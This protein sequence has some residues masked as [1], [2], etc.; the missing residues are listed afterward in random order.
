MTEIT[1]NYDETWKEAIGDYFDSFLAFFYPEIYQQI[2]WSKTPI[3]LDKELEQITASAE[4]ETRHA[5]KLFKVWLLDKQELWILIHVE[6][7]SQY[8]KEFTQRMFIYNY[9]AFDLYQKPVISLAILGD[10]TKSWRPNSY[11][12]GLGSSQLTFNFSIVKLLDYQW[13]ELEQSNNIFAIVV[14]A[15]L[16]T[17]ATNSN[18]SARE[19][20]K[21]NLARLLYERGYNRKEIVDLYK[22]IDLMMALSEDLQ[23][24]FEEKLAH[25]QEERKMPLLTNIEQRAIEKTTKQTL[26]QNIS[27]LLVS[28]FGN[29][30]ENLSGDIGKIQDINILKQLLISTISV[31]SLEEFAQLVNSHL[32]ESD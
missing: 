10:E 21:W 22:V 13:E 20:W 29:L 16:K 19:Q 12:Y 31:N 30:P 5:D 7:Q 26:K 27:D 11:Q 2:D 18:L 3:S 8:D 23:L 17:K 28:R 25:Y 9:R 24:S 4:S 6:V 32:P 1:A 15:H 14:M